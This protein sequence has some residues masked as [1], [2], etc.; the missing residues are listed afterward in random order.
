VGGAALILLDTHAWVW[1]IGGSRELSRRARETIEAAT[2][3]GSVAVSAISCWEIGTLVRKGR[4][5]LTSSAADWIA[6]CEALPFFSVVPVD[7]RI[8]TRASEFAQDHHDPADRIIAATGMTLGV[9]LVTK[10]RRLAAFGVS[11]L[12]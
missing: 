1:W 4:L 11:T 7:S 3:D 12:W 8:A 5:E 6:R 2:T 10:D 9:Q